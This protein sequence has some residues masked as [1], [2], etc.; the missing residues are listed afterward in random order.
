VY[1][2]AFILAFGIWAIVCPESADSVFMAC[3]CVC[4][5]II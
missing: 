2:N 4:F 5:L 1:M 3:I